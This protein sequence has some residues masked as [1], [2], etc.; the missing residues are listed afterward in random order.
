MT[1][2]LRL[3][4][5]ESY[6]KA[7]N[8]ASKGTSREKPEKR[9]IDTKRTFSIKIVRKATASHIKGHEPRRLKSR[10]IHEV[11]ERKGVKAQ[12]LKHEGNLF[13]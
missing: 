3:T 8:A 5:G 12:R 1:E 7:K 13:K 11:N 6:E 9:K 10:H 2:D 4:E